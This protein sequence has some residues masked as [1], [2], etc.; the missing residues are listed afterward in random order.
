MQVN[1]DLFNIK[2]DGLESCGGMF[3]NKGMFVE[4]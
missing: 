1:L 3:I 4:S 2:R